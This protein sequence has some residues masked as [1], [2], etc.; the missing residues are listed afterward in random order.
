MDGLALKIF[1]TD[2]SNIQ[3]QEW[4]VLPQDIKISIERN[5][6]IFNQS[7]T[8]SYPFAIPY[9]DNRHIF[10]ELRLP[11]SERKI[12]E[13][14][15]TYELYCQGIFLFMGDVSI[16]EGTITDSITLQLRSGD[17]S[18]LNKIT[19]LNCRN[20][21]QAENVS[22]GKNYFDRSGVRGYWKTISYPNVEKAYPDA[23]YCNVKMVANPYT[24]E[25]NDDTSELVVP[26]IEPDSV[27]SGICFYVMYLLECIFTMFNIPIEQND[28]FDYED[29]KRLAF[30]TT[31]RKTQSVTIDLDN[32][33][34]IALSDNFPDI[35]VTTV[36]DSLK[37][38]FGIIIVNDEF[39]TKAKVRLI[40]D[41][42]LNY[43]VGNLS[44]KIISVGKIN[45]RGKN[46]IVK[47]DGDEDDTAFNYNDYENVILISSYNEIVAKIK[48]NTLA[49]DDIHCYIDQKTGNAYRVKV[50]SETNDNAAIFE[51]GQFSPYESVKYKDTTDEPEEILISFTPIIVNDITDNEVRKQ[52]NYKI[53][54]A[55]YLDIDMKAEAISVTSTG[56]VVRRPSS[57]GSS[58]GGRTSAS[59]RSN[60]TVPVTRADDY[61]NDRK[62]IKRAKTI[63][64]LDLSSYDAGFTLGI[65]RGPGSDETI[66]DTIDDYVNEIGGNSF[67]TLAG[68]AAFTSDS[69]DVFGRDYD[70]NGAAQGAGGDP[71]DKRISLKLKATKPGYSA[72]AYPN[73]GLVDQFLK[74]YIYF[75]QN[76][77]E[78][79]VVADISL[80]DII[81]IEWD[82]KYY[83]GEYFGFINKLSFDL[84]MNG[85]S[86]TEVEQYMI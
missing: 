1:W 65:M 71:L 16:D 24:V 8:F 86:Y 10:G 39:S 68:N 27:D 29:F 19:D 69:I 31:K 66:D 54:N 63:Y 76:R 7:G 28:M 46:I 33:N 70:Y 43:E 79:S 56:S 23:N 38:A 41:I 52:N 40:K 11:E 45:K 44:A 72:S 34:M 67:I 32:K 15:Y 47:Y 82:K 37:N 26:I 14:N 25:Y 5:S 20:V 55:I 48:D 4:A 12:D 30:F 49:D 18:F 83:L 60:A 75:L 59:T 21:K 62:P 84:D 36:L 51:V 80:D 78:V 17:N 81:G 74:E 42:L 9:E 58:S 35:N 6:P 3:H 73:R 53:E 77:R 22:V 85:I 13:L 57:S 50:D 2:E 61:Y 64:T